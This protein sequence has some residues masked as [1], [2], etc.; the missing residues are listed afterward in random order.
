MVRY[1]PNVFKHR[2]NN[3]RDLFTSKSIFSVPQNRLGDGIKEA[4]SYNSR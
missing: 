4:N 1:K 2:P 3:E